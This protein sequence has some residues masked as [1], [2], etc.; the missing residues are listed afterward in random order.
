MSQL[1][2]PEQEGRL[3]EATKQTQLNTAV[4][5]RTAEVAPTPEA[6]AGMYGSGIAE[7]EAAKGWAQA[8]QSIQEFAMRDL[9][10]RTA[11]ETQRKR[12]YELEYK[13]MTL[14][15]IK[16]SNDEADAAGE[17]PEQRKAR[18]Q[19]YVEEGHSNLTGKYTFTTRVGNDIEK[20]TELWKNGAALHYDM[21]VY[22]PK[23]VD[24]TRAAGEKTIQTVQT[25]LGKQLEQTGYKE[26]EL[27]DA[28]KKINETFDD[29]VFRLGFRNPAEAERARIVAIRELRKEAVS[30][31]IRRDP[32]NA[33]K[34][35]EEQIARQ[36][37]PF[38]NEDREFL[39][40]WWEE[41]N[42][43]ATYSRQRREKVE[44]QQQADL[45]FQMKNFII[46][47]ADTINV[48]QYR[49][50]VNEQ[51][52]QGKLGNDDKYDLLT[53]LDKLTKARQAASEKLQKDREKNT[54]RAAV[55]VNAREFG[56]HSEKERDAVDDYFAE[57]FNAKPFVMQD[58]FVKNEVASTR[59]IPEPYLQNLVRRVRQDKEE[60]AKPALEMLSEYVSNPDTRNQ[61][62]RFDRG[63]VEMALEYKSS[64][65][66][67]L[68]K[69]GYLTRTKLDPEVL[70]DR[71]REF[72][73]TEAM[74]VNPSGTAWEKSLKNKFG[75]AGSVPFT[76]NMPA[77][78]PDTFVD[79][80]NDV[81][82]QTRTR[83]NRP[84]PLSEAMDDA[85]NAVHGQ[86]WRTVQRGG[87]ATIEFK[88]PEMFYT[89]D[90][91]PKVQDEAR[92]D[93]KTRGLNPDEYSLR[94]IGTYS[95]PIDREDPANGRPLFGFAKKLGTR[96]VLLRN[97]DDLR[98]PL[99]FRAD[100][101]VF[102]KAREQARVERAA[103]FDQVTEA[104]QVAA[105]RIAAPYK[106]KKRD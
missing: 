57:N 52:K 85:L 55:L 18:F 56:A 75:V 54:K 98:Q 6:P 42:A 84:V 76:T 43:Q 83:G 25:V 39:K 73:K 63:L 34:W 28:I 87:K 2:I 13:Q 72:D 27:Q 30:L 74:K 44:N 11:E 8:G 51:V 82:K 64:G 16:R 7:Q 31:I 17:T 69:E 53:D 36:D 93:L 65:S 95:N 47:N 20:E 61:I 67:Q 46:E 62:S 88:P 37:G 26:G 49:N 60:V 35:I 91:L 101:S 100:E 1:R 102:R 15:A 80:V 99:M 41:S 29:P 48:A 33:P 97:P 10:L 21:D 4:G 38:A 32:E 104:R 5:T 103:E 12:L 19:Q 66:V 59:Y 14:D 77:V 24:A 22:Q 9:H 90:E 71:E 3:G 45:R 40:Q 81:A 96:E 105:E 50:H 89:Q 23:M 79:A 68:A 78:I 86:G 92:A 94:W 70:K 58:R 106:N